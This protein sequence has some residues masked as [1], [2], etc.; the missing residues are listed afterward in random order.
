MPTCEIRARLFYSVH[1]TDLQGSFARDVRKR[2]TLRHGLVA[3]VSGEV[4]A[5]K[6]AQAA[7]PDVLAGLLAQVNAEV[8]VQ[9]GN[10][11]RF[12]FLPC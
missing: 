3:H 9:P 5:I 8:L 12:V 1:K 4:A 6:G 2:F 7:G 11:H 10:C